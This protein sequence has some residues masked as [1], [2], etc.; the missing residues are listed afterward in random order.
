MKTRTIKNPSNFSFSKKEDI[1]SFFKSAKSDL[2]RINDIKFRVLRCFL[3]PYINGASVLDL[4]CGDAFYLD[5]L[6]NDGLRN[7]TGIDISQVMIDRIK[8]DKKGKRNIRVIVGDMA[9]EK[10]VKDASFDCVL[11]I[12]SLMRIKNVSK[13]FKIVN[14]KIKKGGVFLVMTNTYI[15]KNLELKNFMVEIKKN[16]KVFFNNYPRS[17][18]QFVKTANNQGFTL[19]CNFSKPFSKDK[20]IT[21]PN[22]KK[23]AGFDSILMFEKE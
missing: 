3:N 7:Y 12:F 19:L 8:V 23:I 5:S 10:L 21:S 22:P 11:S 14:K 16:D 13:I 2:K 15:T 18:D 4:G 9:D 6:L 17:A 20:I 1:D